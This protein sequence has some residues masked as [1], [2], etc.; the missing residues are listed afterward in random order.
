MIYKIYT[1]NLYKYIHTQTYLQLYNWTSIFAYSGVQ[2][3]ES[4]MKNR[5]CKDK[6]YKTIEITKIELKFINTM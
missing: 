6:K 5:C 1:L 2:K 3:S 4:N